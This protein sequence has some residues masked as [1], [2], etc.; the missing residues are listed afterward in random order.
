MKRS[1]LFTAA[2]AVA[3]GLAPPSLPAVM[4]ISLPAPAAEG[5]PR[6]PSPPEPP[7]TPE[8]LREALL[9]MLVA[10]AENPARQC[11]DHSLRFNYG[12]MAL[13][14]AKADPERVRD[15]LLRGAA[16]GAEQEQRG[17]EFVLWKTS[18]SPGIVAH[19]RFDWC[20]AQQGIESPLGDVGLRCFQ[21][22]GVPAIAQLRKL[23]GAGQA[24]T[25]AHLQ[26]IYGK[27]LPAKYLGDVATAIYQAADDEQSFGVQRALFA[28]CIKQVR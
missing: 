24:D 19:S 20:L 5:V 4:D 23:G 15:S 9:F 14:S 11:L 21:L 10:E 28:G 3:L 16:E 7:P 12:L 6:P 18:S 8:Q 26:G 22:A 17:R 13:R 25:L 1:T 27:T 2:L